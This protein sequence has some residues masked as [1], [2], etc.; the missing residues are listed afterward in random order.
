MK[1]GSL[2][3]DHGETRRP[4]L[5]DFGLCLSFEDVVL[6]CRRSTNGQKRSWMK[7][8]VKT[9]GTPWSECGFSARLC[10]LVSGC[11]EPV[12]SWV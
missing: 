10:I 9:R 12:P 8:I 4:S 1:E 2:G 6:T 7:I 11:Q 5:S 3:E